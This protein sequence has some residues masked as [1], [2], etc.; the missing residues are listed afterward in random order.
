MTPS[1]MACL[2]AATWLV[3]GQSNGFGE[4]IVAKGLDD[5]KSFGCRCGKSLGQS[6]KSDSSI[7]CTC[8]T[9]VTVKMC[10]HP[11]GTK[12]KALQR[13]F[14][15][16]DKLLGPATLFEQACSFDCGWKVLVPESVDDVGGEIC[17]PNIEVAGLHHQHGVDG[18]RVH[19][20]RR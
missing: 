4:V 18:P 7:G 6:K 19:R 5:G 11:R 1:A 8:E 16:E 10:C 15:R 12:H 3:L 20:S 13:L 17:E 9:R 2:T 14:Y